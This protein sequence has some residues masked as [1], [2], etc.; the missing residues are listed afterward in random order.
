MKRPNFS[1]K[2][3]LII[4]GVAILAVL[5]MDFNSRVGD[6]RRQSAQK[7][8]VSA[9]LAGQNQ[10]QTVLQTQIAYATSEAAVVEWAYNEGNLVRPGDNPVVPLAPEGSAPMPTPTPVTT[11]E[12]VSNLDV[13]LWLFFDEAGL[14]GARAG[15]P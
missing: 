5:V 4:V 12:R 7:Q 8:V 1:L 14:P 2:H 10:T 11:P 15:T 9:E 3:A 13:W 6:L